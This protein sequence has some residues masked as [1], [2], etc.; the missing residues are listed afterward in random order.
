MH[1]LFSSLYFGG[2]LQRQVLYLPHEIPLFPKICRGGYHDHLRGVETDP[3][4]VIIILTT[5]LYPRLHEC[6]CAFLTG[7][8]PV[9]SRHPFEGSTTSP[10][11]IALGLY[12]VLFA[13]DG[14]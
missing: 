5:L 4:M 12:G 8:F 13:Y 9:D 3:K 10:S 11:D 6:Y 14:W 1:R 2:C 7:S